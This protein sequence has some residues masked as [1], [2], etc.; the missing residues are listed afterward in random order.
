[1]KEGKRVMECMKKALRISNQC[2]DPTVQV[3][4]FVELL[5]RYLYFYSKGCEEVWSWSGWAQ[6]FP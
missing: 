4:L 2:M 6:Y 5:N 3:Q 1:M